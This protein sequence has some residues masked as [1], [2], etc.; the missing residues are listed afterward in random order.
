M[1][2]YWKLQRPCVGKKISES[3]NF[4]L[5]SIVCSFT[6]NNTCYRWTEC[7]L[8]LAREKGTLN[9][10]QENILILATFMYIRFNFS[11]NWIIVFLI[12]GVS[13]SF[14]FRSIHGFLSSLKI[15]VIFSTFQQQTIAL[16]SWD[17]SHVIPWTSISISK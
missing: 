14:C 3:Q 12:S 11:H 2:G 8:L 4:K 10:L 16:Y 5:N 1:N 7:S 6:L 9:R 17:Y 13:L 15:L